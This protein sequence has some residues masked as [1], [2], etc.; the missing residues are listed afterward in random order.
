MDSNKRKIVVFMEYSD[1]LSHYDIVAYVRFT[2]ETVKEGFIPDNFRSCADAPPAA[3]P[4]LRYPTSTVFEGSDIFQRTFQF[5]TL[6]MY[7]IVV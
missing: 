3:P 5:S 7:N 2:G 1:I 6:F 4:G